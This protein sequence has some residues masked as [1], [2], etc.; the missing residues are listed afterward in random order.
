MPNAVVLLYVAA[1]GL[2]LFAWLADPRG[3]RRA[4]GKAWN[5]AWTVAGYGAEW[6]RWRGVPWVAG[7]VRWRFGRR[8]VRHE[9]R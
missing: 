4:W 2:L 6:L 1:A 8:T 3:W 9:A 5:N 7:L